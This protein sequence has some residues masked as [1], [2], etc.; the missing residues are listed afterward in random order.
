MPTLEEL[1]RQRMENSKA[2]GGD[3][4][5]KEPEFDSEEELG[6]IPKGSRQAIV[7][8]RLTKDAQVYY[9]LRIFYWDR[10]EN[11]FKPSPKGVMMTAEQF[12][13]IVELVKNIHV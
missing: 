1:A 5:K 13:Q 3:S 2:E 9:D 12:K 8:R 6:A 4:R 11:A 10:V 7:M